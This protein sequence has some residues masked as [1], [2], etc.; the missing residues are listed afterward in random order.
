[1]SLTRHVSPRLRGY[2]VIAAGAML[3]AIAGGRP[4]LVAVA[5]VFLTFLLVG[6]TLARQ[7][8]ID[9]TTALARERGLEGEPLPL[10]LTARSRGGPAELS[11]TL[12]PPEGVDAP[13]RTWALAP[14]PD[15]EVTVRAVLVPRRWGV[16]GAGTV[17]VEVSDP[18][19]LFRWRGNHAIE[20]QVRVYPRPERLQ[21][22]I[23]PRSTQSLTGNRVA[24]S[25]GD[26]MEFAEVRPF[27]SGDR[28][29]RINWAASSRRGEL[30][31]N[32]THPDRNADVVLFLDTFE[33][34][35]LGSEGTLD[36]GMRAAT[37]LASQYLAARDRVGVVSFGGVLNWL[38][39]ALGSRAGYR[40]AD[41]LLQAE[42]VFSFVT[43][44]LDV[45]PRRLLPSGALVIALTPLLDTRTITALIDIRG[46]GYDLAIVE[47][48]PEPFMPPPRTS[49]QDLARRLWRL[50][51]E[52][53]RS[54][55][56]RQ[57]V[58]IVRWEPGQALSIP[59]AA[60]SAARRQPQSGR[61]A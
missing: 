46:R 59:I 27:V 30:F 55:L 52:A 61:V 13:Q 29:R 37:S 50:E 54:H 36:L 15:G 22:L 5:A 17:A 2:A 9:L 20:G 23:A 8:A 1:M 48:D 53:L 34:T 43:K 32:D 45:I 41:A 42:I 4:A 38:E 26:G 49:E 40:I 44:T 19:R 10:A 60:M 21:T 25:R 51:R 12:S 35:R 7:P 16:R 31:V 33:E 47:C 24:R 14:P 11:L 57:G 28:A 18:L 58:S 6:V 3:A 39:P 56:R